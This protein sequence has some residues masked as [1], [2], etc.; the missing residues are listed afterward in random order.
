MGAKGQRSKYRG[1]G[2]I[3][4]NRGIQMHSVTALLITLSR[5]GGGCD[6]PVGFTLKI[7]FDQRQEN[8]RESRWKMAQE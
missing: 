6:A 7:H 3:L 4:R 1:E 8:G 5:K 2:G